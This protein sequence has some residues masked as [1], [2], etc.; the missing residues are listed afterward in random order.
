VI[1]GQFDVEV[2]EV[3]EARTTLSAETAV[4]PTNFGFGISDC[5]LE[6]RRTI[7]NLKFQI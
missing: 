2:W 7:S 6:E 5:G 4:T 3:W 1:I